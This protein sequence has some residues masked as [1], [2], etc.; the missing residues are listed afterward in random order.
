MLALYVYHPVTLGVIY[1]AVIKWVFKIWPPGTSCWQDD[2][3]IVAQNIQT[4]VLYQNPQSLLH[5][6]RYLWYTNTDVTPILHLLVSW[7]HQRSN[8][9]QYCKWAHILQHINY[10]SRTSFLHLQ[11]GSEGKPQW[12]E[13]L[14]Y[15]NLQEAQSWIC[16][17]ICCCPG[18]KKYFTCI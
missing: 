12:V 7:F 17:H 10:S 13:Q 1:L 11:T 3:L 4:L 16:I 18:C 6:Y 14:T 15:R 8:S 5:T 9:W 2:R